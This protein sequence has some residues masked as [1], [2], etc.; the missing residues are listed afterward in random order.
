MKQWFRFTIRDWFWF[1]LLVA[2][3]V[4]FAQRYSQ[5][6]TER[7]FHQKNV[8]LRRQF[9]AQISKLEAERQSL[10]EQLA[11]KNE[12]AIDRELDLQTTVRALKLRLG[13][14]PYGK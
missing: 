5:L 4:W 6:E 7:M 1:S 14:D 2:C 9:G 12:S 10:E 3:L 13:E 8:Q 11:A